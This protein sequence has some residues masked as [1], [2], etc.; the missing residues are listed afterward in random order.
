MASKCLDRMKD[1]YRLDGNYIKVAWATNKGIE[2]EKRLREF[3]NVDVGCTYIPWT[4]LDTYS[5]ESIEFSKWAVGGLVDEDSLPEKYLSIY[6]NQMLKLA[7]SDNSISTKII[8][9]NP[10]NDSND[11]DL[12]TDEFQESLPLSSNQPSQ[13]PIQ[14]I[15]FQ[16]LPQVLPLNFTT[17]PPTGQI[18]LTGNQFLSANSALSQNQ[19]SLSSLQVHPLNFPHLRQFN[20]VFSQT[21]PNQESLITPNQ[22]LLDL[23]NSQR[24]I[25]TLPAFG[26]TPAH[27]QFIQRPLL[28][29]HQG[30]APISLAQQTVVPMRKILLPLQTLPSQSE[31][32]KNTTETPEISSTTQNEDKNE[33][34]LDNR[35]HNGNFQRNNWKH[36]NNQYGNNRRSYGNGNNETNRNNY[37]NSQRYSN[38]SNGY[39]N[40]SNNN[41][42]NK[43]SSFRYNGK[44]PQ[45]GDRT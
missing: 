8:E 7:N 17:P 18:P 28:M 34:K 5:S 12:D 24:N 36:N 32:L 35:S 2:K 6:K 37:G 13:Q 38:R 22:N 33:R 23:L 20:P 9:V 45:N 40:N 16:N 15:Q 39:S 21:E 41:N 43:N 3:W 29:N 10:K 27:F 25:M 19:M 42:I 14:Q 26:A 44:Y 30:Q 31:E 4:H 11:M 1:S